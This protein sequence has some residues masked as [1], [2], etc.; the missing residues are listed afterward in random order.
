MVANDYLICFILSI[1]VA[2]N[3]DVLW[4]REVW[5]WLSKLLKTDS[6]NYDNFYKRLMVRYG[7]LV[8]PLFCSVCRP[9]LFCAAIGLAL[10][11][12]MGLPLLFA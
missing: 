1:A 5:K 12:L 9:S 10:S 6:P 2:A 4:R 3:M 7:N 11:F 8:Y